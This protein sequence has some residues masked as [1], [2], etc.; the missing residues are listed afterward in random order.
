LKR[1]ACHDQG[2]TLNRRRKEEKDKSKE[3][4][5]RKKND[6]TKNPEG[7]MQHGRCEKQ[8]VVHPASQDAKTPPAGER[9][10]PGRTQ[11]RKAENA[12]SR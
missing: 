9:N 7:D 3:K 5:E 10:K 8:I 2:V 11:R 6:A 4:G 1:H 12:K